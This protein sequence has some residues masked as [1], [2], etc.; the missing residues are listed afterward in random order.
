MQKNEDAGAGWYPD[1]RGKLRWWNG[2]RWTPDEPDDGTLA[3]A[4][5]GAP[6]VP[7]ALAII[8]LTVGGAGTI[9]AVGSVI[10]Y[11]LSAR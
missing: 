3:P 8:A 4:R 5:A 1:A 6:R 11:M 9:A 2:Q 7:R 10:A